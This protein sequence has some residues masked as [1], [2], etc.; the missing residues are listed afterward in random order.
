MP[1][2]TIIDSNPRHAVDYDEVLAVG[3]NDSES[4]IG[5]IISISLEGEGIVALP[6]RAS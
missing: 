2:V 4:S 6:P 3:T 1:I 5:L